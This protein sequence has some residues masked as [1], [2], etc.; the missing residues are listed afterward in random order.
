MIIYRALAIA[1]FVFCIAIIASLP[2]N[3]YQP[4]LHKIAVK[5]EGLH[6]R[7]NR[8]KLRKVLG[9][10]P[11]RTP[12][13]GAFV[14]LVVQRAGSKPVNGHLRAVNWSNY[15]KKSSLKNIK[16]GDIV[17]WRHH[18]GI[19]TGKRIKGK[20]EIVSG[21]FNNQVETAYRTTRGLV[22]VR[23]GGK[24]QKLNIFKRLKQRFKVER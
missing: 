4:I 11:V 24:L 8:S 20:V 12:W 15:G 23:R 14:G 6:E 18:V 22:A 21:N 16:S 19:A 9:V 13:C 17:V 7:S 2:A 3:A 1:A 5:Y 10:D